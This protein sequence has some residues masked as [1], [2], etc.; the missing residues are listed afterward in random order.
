M[1]LETALHARFVTKLRVP[2]IEIRVVDHDRQD[3]WLSSQRWMLARVDEGETKIWNQNLIRD[4]N[5]P[6]EWRK[7]I[8]LINK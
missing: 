3:P 1:L 4:A 8:F 7:E 2:R 6:C 5:R